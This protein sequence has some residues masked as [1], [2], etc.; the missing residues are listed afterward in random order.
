VFDEGVKDF[1]Y[2]N[3]GR[4]NNNY[5][6]DNL[7]Y[8]LDLNILMEEVILVNVTTNKREVMIWK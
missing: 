2:C 6:M 5:V 7:R 8:I 1:R 3:R 4:L